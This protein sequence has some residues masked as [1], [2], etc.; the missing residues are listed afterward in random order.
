MPALWFSASMRS[1]V[2]RG[3][4]KPALS[5]AARRSAWRDVNLA[6]DVYARAFREQLERVKPAPQVPEWERQLIDDWAGLSSR[7]PAAYV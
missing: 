4:K 7:P 3:R 1:A 2:K 6:Q 5:R